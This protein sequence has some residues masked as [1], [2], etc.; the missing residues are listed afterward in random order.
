MRPLLTVN[1]AAKLL[2]CH[3]THIRR[4]CGKKRIPHIPGKLGIGVKFN[5]E[6]LE[7]WVREAEIEPEK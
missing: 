3:P 6:K 7:A 2:H 1:E 5:P 4:L